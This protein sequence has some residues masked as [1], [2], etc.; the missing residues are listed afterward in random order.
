MGEKDVLSFHV[1][2]QEKGNVNQ[3]KIQHVK[4]NLTEPT[5]PFAI[6]HDK[7]V[8]F[9]NVIYFIYSGLEVEPNYL[10]VPFN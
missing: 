6:F 4:K 3:S 5:V 8:E 1:N 7:L 2:C 10:E 9:W